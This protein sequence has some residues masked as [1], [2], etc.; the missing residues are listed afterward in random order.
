V[1]ASLLVALCTRPEADL[2]I[3]TEPAKVAAPRI[4]SHEPAD[5]QPPGGVAWLADWYPA[6]WSVSDSSATCYAQLRDRLLRA[7]SDVVGRQPA[8][9]GEATAVAEEVL[10]YHQLLERLLE[11]RPSGATKR[12]PISDLD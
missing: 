3:H 4:A 2:A 8:S 11:N 10:S 6:S 1:A 9:P 12:R 5:Q 7:E